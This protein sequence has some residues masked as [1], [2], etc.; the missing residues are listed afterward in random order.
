MRPVQR[1]H[2]LVGGVA[3]AVVIGTV[4]ALQGRSTS[5]PSTSAGGKPTA[6]AAAGPAARVATTGNVYAHTGVGM[7]APA[8][9]GVPY[10]LYVPESAGTGVDVIDPNKMRVIAH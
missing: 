3:L 10:L 5:Q 8:A 6:V 4:M 2:L 1:R 7:F 9:R